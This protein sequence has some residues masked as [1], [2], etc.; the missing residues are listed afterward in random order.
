ME[1]AGSRFWEI[2]FAE[3]LLQQDNRSVCKGVGSRVEW[4]VVLQ[5]EI[6]WWLGAQIGK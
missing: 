3:S 2:E 6:V 1:P 4:E 5:R